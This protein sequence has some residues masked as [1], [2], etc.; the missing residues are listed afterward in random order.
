MS[1]NNL[2]FMF[3][4]TNVNFGAFDI[5]TG[6]LGG[7]TVSLPNASDQ[8]TFTKGA[9]VNSGVVFS[10]NGSLRNAPGSQ[11][12]VNPGGAVGVH[13]QNDGELNVAGNANVGTITLKSLSSGTTAMVAANIG[14]ATPGTQFDRIEVTNGASLDGKLALTTLNGYNPAYLA[15]HELLHVAA[16]G[17]GV[18]G[19]FKQITGMQITPTKFWAV[20]YNADRVFATAAR[21]GDADLNGVINFDDYSKTDFGYNNQ[22]P[23]WANGDFDGNGQVNFD[24]YALI[25]LNFNTQGSSLMAAARWLTGEDRSMDNASLPGVRS[26]VQHFE[27]FG[28][29]Y[30]NAFLASPCRSQRV[31]LQAARWRSRCY[32]VDDAGRKS[33]PSKN[34]TGSVPFIFRSDSAAEDK[35][36]DGPYYFVLVI[37]FGVVAG[38]DAGFGGLAVTATPVARRLAPSTTTDSVPSKPFVTSTSSPRLLPSRSWCSTAFPCSSIVKT[39]STPAN[40]TTASRGTNTTCS[41]RRVSIDACANAPGFSIC[42]SFG[43]TTS[44]WNVRLAGSICGLMRVTWPSNSSRYA[45]IRT[46]TRW[47]TCTS[48]T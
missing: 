40:L 48:A 20:T 23:G 11:F 28:Q 27:Q 42:I 1:G 26:V 19:H 46:R 21:P 35:N 33:T 8:L 13:L 38:L 4:R 41:S 9:I 22:L 47:P 18:S 39:F 17:N 30:A 25:D 16:S 31:R 43:T 7:S 2:Q 24:D 45:S 6:F 12:A 3:G 15:S 37:W 44:T 14:G 36:R 29:P 34:K 5:Q 32:R 10:G